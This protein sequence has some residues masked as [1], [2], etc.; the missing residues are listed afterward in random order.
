MRVSPPPRNASALRPWLGLYLVL[1]SLASPFFF[2][3]DH[4]LLTTSRVAHS[5]NNDPFGDPHWEL[6]SLP[7]EGEYLFLCH[8]LPGQDLLGP[9]P[10]EMAPTRTVVAHL[11]SL[12]HLRA[13]DRLGVLCCFP[14]SKVGGDVLGV[15]VYFLLPEHPDVVQASAVW[16]FVWYRKSKS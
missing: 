4:V 16:R 7:A 2:L 10:G 5:E 11:L 8:G 9:C 12:G 14:D 3:E 15:T 6:F 1:L 13:G